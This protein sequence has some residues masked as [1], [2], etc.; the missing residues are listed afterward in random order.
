VITVQGSTFPTTITP[1]N[2][3]RLEQTDGTVTLSVTPFG[4]SIPGGI[5]IASADVTGDGKPDLIAATG[6]GVL[7]EVAVFDGVTGNKIQD[8]SPF[9]GFTGGL[10]VSTG[11]L[12]GDGIPDIVVTPDD[13]GGP[14]VTVYRTSDYTV[15]ANFFGIGDPS[16]RGGARAAVGDINHDGVN[17]LIVAAGPGGGPRVVVYD[18]NSLSG[19]QYTTKLVSDFFAFPDTIRNG[20]Y[21]A[22]G[23]VNGDGFDDL[24]IGAGAGGGP[25]V[26][27]L[28][29][30][31]LSQGQQ[32]PL[33]SFFAG[34]PNR[35]DGVPVAAHDVNG[36]GLADII[37][38]GGTT[39]TVEIFLDNNLGAPSSQFDPFAGFLGGVNV[40]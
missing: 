22:S 8:F 38:G 13:G 28:S 25:A 12:S 39:S 15:I 21:V 40:G 1:P 24:I 34:D 3:V 2:Q 10:F 16:F 23:D 19:G 30:Q 7:D 31:A 29:G 4:A 33:A 36:D 26:L 35:R 5:R 17:D 20:V 32:T 9:P 27:V 6:P 18:G 37:T 14:R 11:D